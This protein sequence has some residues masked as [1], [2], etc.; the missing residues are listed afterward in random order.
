MILAVAGRRVDPVDAKQ[1]RFPLINV[2]TV[3]M[4]VRALLREKGATALVASAACGA[5]LIALSEAAG[6]GIRPRVILPFERQRFRNTSV[7]DRPGH[8]GPLYDQ[9]LDDVEPMGDL[10]V[11]QNG[12]GDDAYSAANSVILDEAVDLGKSTDQPVAALLIWDGTSRGGH[13]LTEEFGVKAR[14]RGLLVTEILT[15]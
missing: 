12:S 10:V 15:R 6:L 9:I 8:W 7:T 13:D 5:D 3:R 1:A 14:K 2:D 4:R 11:L